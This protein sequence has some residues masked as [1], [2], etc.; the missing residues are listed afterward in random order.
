M[1]NNEMI[2]QKVHDIEKQDIS[3]TPSFLAVE[4]AKYVL[5]TAT[6]LTLLEYPGHSIYFNP[7]ESLSICSNR[8]AL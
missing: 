4:R 2:R 8:W 1:P 7:M 5:G 6:Y 3:Q